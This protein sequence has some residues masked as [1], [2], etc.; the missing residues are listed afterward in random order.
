[1]QWIGRQVK[2][3]DPVIDTSSAQLGGHKSLV[4]SFGIIGNQCQQPSAASPIAPTLDGV[5][6]RRAILT[7]SRWKIYL[8]LTQLNPIS[9]Q[10]RNSEDD[11]IQ[12]FP[13]REATAVRCISSG[14]VWQIAE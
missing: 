7:A 6:S 14:Y 2:N 11:R 1:M 13:K 8:K 12:H 5:I 4:D 10:L 9:P 3:I